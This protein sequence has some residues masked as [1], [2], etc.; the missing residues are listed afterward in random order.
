M[1]KTILFLSFCALLVNE[2]CKKRD[3]EDI[4]TTYDA[5]YPTITFTGSKFV[6]IPVGGTVPAI[7]ATAYDSILNESTTVIQGPSTVDV[8]KPGLYFQEF[9]SKNSRGFRATDIAYVAV[10]DIAESEDQSGDYKCVGRNGIATVT[11]LANG[12]YRSD[13]VGGNPAGPVTVY[14][15]QLTDTTLK[16]PTQPTAAGTMG[17]TNVSFTPGVSYEY[18]VVNPGYGTGLRVFEKQ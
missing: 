18:K 1:K 9:A 8:T 11:E 15:V 3:P 10:T 14:F 13:N 2:G 4:S 7:A 16:F 5:T 12:L 17:F 6:S